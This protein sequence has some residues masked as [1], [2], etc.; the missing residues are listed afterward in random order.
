M[1]GAGRLAGLPVP[2]WIAGTV[3]ILMALFLR[4]H[5]VG[6]A[7]Y[8]IGGNAEA[9]RTAG[10]NVDRVRFLIFVA[11]GV[12][13]ALAGIMLTGRISAATSNQGANLIFSTL[14]A[15]VIGGVSMNGGRG[16][17]FGAFLGVIL[18]GLVQN[19]LLL[20]QVATYWI[21][22]TYGAIIVAALL[23]SRIVGGTSSQ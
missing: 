12:L 2:I 4:Y 10:I 5:W 3:L 8:A 13:A 16:N 23:L 20:A 18:L 21:E 22:A 9:A 1:L 15:A 6:R 7:I 17:L 14:A 11:A 19:V